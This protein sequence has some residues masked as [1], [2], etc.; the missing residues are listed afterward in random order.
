MATSRN[1]PLT[2]KGTQTSVPLS[3]LWTDGLAQ[4]CGLPLAWNHPAAAPWGED[5]HRSFSSR[6]PL[7]VTDS[8]WMNS[9]NSILP[10]WQ[11]RGGGGASVSTGRLTRPNLG[12]VAWGAADS[13]L[14]RGVKG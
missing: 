2:R 13:Y 12:Q 7:E 8:A 3:Q 4:F 1:P 9:E 14:G 11:E 6:V 5:L 10:S